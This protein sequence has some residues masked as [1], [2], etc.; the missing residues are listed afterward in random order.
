MYAEE[1]GCSMTQE[2]L[3]DQQ[4]TE[5]PVNL[6]GK[7]G[8][9]GAGE[10]GKWG[11]LGAAEGARGEKLGLLAVQWLGLCTSTAQGTICTVQPKGKK[12]SKAEGLLVCN[13]VHLN[14]TGSSPVPPRISG[15]L[16]T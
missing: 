2:L 8:E 3:R 9:R 12:L 11:V 14:I 1:K 4:G 6:G 7:D 5:H 16:D 10:R 15:W 13:I